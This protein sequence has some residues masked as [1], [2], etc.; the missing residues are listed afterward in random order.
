VQVLNGQLY[1]AFALQAAGKHDD[2]PGAGHGFVDVF[3]LD[4]TFVKRLIDVGATDPLDSP[5]G[6]AIAPAGFGDFANDCWSGTSAT[7]RSNAFNPAS[8]AFLGA[9]LDGNGNPIS[10]DGLWRSPL[11][12][13]APGSIPTRSTSPP[14]STVKRTVSSAIW[15]SCRSPV[16]SPFWQPA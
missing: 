14:V 1:V 5:W 13:A 10:I 12:M 6:L 16:L 2:D 8:G 3:N 7:A 11:V 4:G 15:R 9:L